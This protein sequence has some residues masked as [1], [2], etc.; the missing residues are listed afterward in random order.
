M[1]NFVVSITIGSVFV[2]D[3]LPLLFGYCRGHVLHADS[4]LLQHIVSRNLIREWR[5][6]QNE[7]IPA[8]VYRSILLNSLC[9]VNK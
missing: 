5:R 9:N 6:E 4:P 7:F 3:D 2:C 1:F 8:C